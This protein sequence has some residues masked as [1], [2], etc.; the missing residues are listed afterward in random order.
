M[1]IGKKSVLSEVALA[2]KLGMEKDTVEAI[3]NAI[4]GPS[5]ATSTFVGKNKVAIGIIPEKVSRNNHPWSVHAIT[6]M[7]K[8][9]IPKGQ[10]SQIIMV[11]A[12]AVKYQGALTAAVAK[13]FPVYSKK[14]TEASRKGEDESQKNSRKIHMALWDEKGAPLACPPDA[15]TSALAAAEG[16]QLAARLVDSPPEELTTDAYAAECKRL[17]EELDGVSFKEIVGNDLCEKGYGGIYG[18]GKAAVCPPRLVIMEYTPPGATPEGKTIC[19]VGKAI[20]Y[21]TGGLSLKP[22]TG[23]CGMK[24]DMGGSAGLLGGF[25]SAVKAGYPNKLVYLVCMAENAI[26]PSAFRNDDILTMY[27]GKTVEVNNCDAEGRLVLG[28]GVAHASKHI[29][30]LDLIVD[31]ATLTGAQMVTTGQKHAGILT[32]KAELEV[33]A[34]AAGLQSG[35]LAYPMLY[36]PELL[37]KEFNSKVADMKN[38]VKDRSNAQS[39]CAG[40]FIEAHLDENYEG[41]WLHVDMAGPATENER[42]TGYGVG[43]VL[44]LLGVAGF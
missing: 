6:E 14:T 40:H 42:G 34:V 12:D 5:G 1:V 43:L 36:A 38:S 24:A 15:T 33:K 8:S 16:I 31:M 26:G 44:S 7:V 32:N 10:T 28:D 29:E 37:K 22:K 4:D 3:M 9:H 35:D 21:D 2:G 19:L 25:V 20:V 18:V 30:N 13:A 17:A 39:S 23:M 27:S 41:G 11:G